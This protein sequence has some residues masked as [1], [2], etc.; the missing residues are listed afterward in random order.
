MEAIAET[1]ADF[2]RQRQLHGSIDVLIP[3]PPSDTTRPFQPVYEMARKI[4]RRTG[5][6]VNFDVLQK[7]KNTAPLKDIEDLATRRDILKDAFWMP[8][9]ALWGRRV[10]I[11]DD[12]YRSGATLCAIYRVVRE[13]GQAGWVYALTITKT[14]TKR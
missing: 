5:I 6:F 9:R 11:F 2:L 13:E 12:L 4:G 14:R 10:L 7:T 1:V 3:A 8:P